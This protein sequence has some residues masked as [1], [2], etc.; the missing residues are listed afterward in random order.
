MPRRK[1]K[2]L[3][4]GYGIQ[5]QWYDETQRY[6]EF[7]D[8]LSKRL[9]KIMRDAK[10]TNAQMA[11]K[12]QTNRQSISEFAKRGGITAE[13]RNGERKIRKIPAY[14]ILRYAE[15]TGV[16]P[17]EILGYETKN[18]ELSEEQKELIE[19]SKDFDNKQ[20]QLL[21]KIAKSINE[22]K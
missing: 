4:N 16:S 15:E 6:I 12:L 10:I 21:I 13:E 18:D 17:N 14:L 9:Y 19:I 20:L 7:C 11:D 3:Q 22:T 5:I 2:P 1:E 8:T